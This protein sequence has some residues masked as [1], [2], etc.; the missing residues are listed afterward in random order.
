MPA[1]ALDGLRVI[2][3]TS[4]MSGPYCAMILG[5]LGADVV[6]VERPGVGDDARAMSPHVGGE[7]APF[8]IWNRNKRSITVDLKQPDG[9]AI[10]RRLVAGADVV[11]EN[12]RPGTAA[13]LGLGAETLCGAHPRLIYC[14]ISGFGQ[15]GP[16]ASRGGF[17]R[18][19]QGM[20]GLMSINGEPG[21]RPL[22]VPIPISDIGTG[23]FGA[24]GILAALAARQTTGRGQVVD[25]SLLETPIAWALYEAAQLFATGTVPQRLGAG[26]RTSAPYQA[27]RTAD[28][29][30]N[31]GGGSNHLW[32]SICRVLGTQ[33][34]LDD[35]R[36]TTPGLRV[37]HRAELEAILEP[38]FMTAPTADW[39][40]KLEAAGVPAGPIYDYAQ[41][42]SDPHV[43]ARGMVQEIDHPAA[44]K[45]RTLGVPYK[46]SATPGT[47]RRPAPTLGQHTDEILREAGYDEA[48]IAD[49]HAR[50]VV[51]R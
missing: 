13:R 50:K 25:A 40:A 45:T 22:P 11:I 47:I 34:L 2:D 29:W 18:I 38:I 44:G 3:L 31:L 51:S 36:F 6:K 4:Q 10:V 48:T 37:Q 35:P 32:A 27:F 17:D 15:T 49:F 33:P 19:A 8:M 20:A 16:Y 28:G 23:M 1:G 42:F 12:W 14:S 30:L 21:G 43:R 26:H 39:L 9:L 5:D 41:V 7:S 46:L 24:I